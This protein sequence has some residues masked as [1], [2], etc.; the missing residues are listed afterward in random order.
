MMRTR[1]KRVVNIVAPILIAIGLVALFWFL[2]QGKYIPVLQPSGEV[3]YAQ[4][5]ILIFATVLS[6]LVVIPVFALLGYFAVKYRAG[7]TKAKYMPEWGE[8][9]YLEGLWWGIPI[10]IIG[11]LGVTIYTTSHSLDPYK[12]LSGGT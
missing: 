8:N 11:I 3:G 4:R 7:N 12:Q 1:M 6:L 5:N 10:L 9:K 2:I